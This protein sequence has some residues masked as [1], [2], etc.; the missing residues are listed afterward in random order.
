MGMIPKS[1]THE[2]ARIA[3]EA[4]ALVVRCRA[5]R[6][7]TCKA[8]RCGRTGP[9]AGVS[10]WLSGDCWSKANPLVVAEGDGVASQDE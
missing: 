6:E 7:P 1:T 4:G 9:R 10:H 3:I 2:L 5:E 8:E